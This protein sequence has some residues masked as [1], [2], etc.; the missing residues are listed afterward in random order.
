MP[1]EDLF[2]RVQAGWDRCVQ[3]VG[4]FCVQPSTWRRTHCSEA[5]SMQSTLGPIPADKSRVHYGQVTSSSFSLVKQL[6]L[7]KAFSLWLQV[8]YETSPHLE[9]TAGEAESLT[10]HIHFTRLLFWLELFVPYLHLLR[11][12]SPPISNHTHLPPSPPFPSLMSPIS[13]VPSPYVTTLMGIF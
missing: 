7:F 2:K 8:S 12:A 13:C 3:F 10:W 6:F 11:S 9:Q 5:T 4:M 1:N